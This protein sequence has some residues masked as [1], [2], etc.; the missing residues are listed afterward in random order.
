M[1]VFIGLGIILHSISNKRRHT[2]DLKDGNPG[3]TN[4]VKVYGPLEGIGLSG[5]AVGV[6]LVPVDAG[7]VVCAIVSCHVQLARPALLVKRGDG[8][9]QAHAIL[10]WLR[11]DKRVFI[12]IFCV[13]VVVQV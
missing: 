13:V 11:T 6:I 1:S 10:S 4:V 3:I 7:G 8:A 2:T 12:I 5:R 9:A